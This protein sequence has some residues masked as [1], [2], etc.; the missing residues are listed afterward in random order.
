MS[1]LS[2]RAVIKGGAAFGIAT[3]GFPGLLLG[4]GIPSRQAA[5]RQA[6][7]KKPWLLGWQGVD[8]ATLATEKIAIEGRIPEDLDG[9]LYR[10]GPARHEV[11]DLRYNHWFDGDGMLQA[12]RFGGG[13]LTHR[14]KMIVTSKYAGEQAAGRAIHQT[15]D[16]ATP[17]LRAPTDADSI[18]VAN[19]NVIAHGGELLALWE[20]GSAY[21]IEAGSLDTLG[22]KTWSPET[23]GAPFG[24]HPR[25]DRDGRLWNIGYAPGAGRL[26]IYEISPQG[27]LLRV[28]ALPFEPMPMIHDFMITEHWIVIPLPPFA[29]RRERDGSFLDRFEWDG[30]AAMRFLILDKADLSEVRT[31]ETDA[32]WAFH[33][34]NAWE[35]KDGNIHFDFPR[36]KD[37]SIMT[38][39]LRD[40]MAG[41]IT[42]FG[43]SDYVR[44]EIDIATGR[45]RLEAIDGMV[46]AD[47]PRIDPRFGLVRHRHT[48]MAARL[49][50][51]LEPPYAF[52][53]VVRADIDSG[54]LDSFTYPD[55]ELVEE[56]IVVPRND[57]GGSNK[58][59]AWVLGTT[60]DITRRQTVLNI[61]AFDRLADGPVARARLPYPLPLGLHGNYIPS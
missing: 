9:V 13:K 44:A 48:L 59:D 39:S 21:R 4:E 51:A 33:F 23:R 20:G 52:D 12:F 53:S 57:T 35:S 42:A 5:F 18:N 17:D 32:F 47:F 6:L 45:I 41:K 54:R 14:G 40:V 50:D 34:A 60:L 56:H 38:R 28:K 36:Y 25:R 27:K 16:T 7:A 55:N 1:V 26:V 43:A 31:V 61:F 22:V 2:R 10:N 37:P 8:V 49:G 11:G 19:I 46:A 29:F 24:A 30:S 3:T 15:F 58:G